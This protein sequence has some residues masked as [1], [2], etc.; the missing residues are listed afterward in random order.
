MPD[1]KLN[2]DEDLLEG[3]FLFADND[4][5]TEAGLET[6][7]IISL[8]SDRRAKDSDILPDPAN[9]DKR[10]WWGDLLAEFE[11][12]QIGS[13]LWLLSREKTTQEILQRAKEY[14]EEALQ[15]M[16]DDEIAAKVEVITERNYEKADYNRLDLRANIYKTDGNTLSF[17]FNDIWAEQ[18]LN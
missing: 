2:W 12:D 11:G 16:I 13:R 18:F 8:F 7:V 5:T 1:I 10:G 17:K 14:A 15:W 6:A 4:L 3:D 9:Q